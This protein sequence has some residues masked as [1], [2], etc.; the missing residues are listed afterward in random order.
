M[1]QKF[2]EDA[3]KTRIFQFYERAQVVLTWH[4]QISTSFSRIIDGNK[5]I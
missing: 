5:I 3:V 4:I 2:G 1:Q